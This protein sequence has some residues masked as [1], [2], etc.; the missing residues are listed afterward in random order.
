MWDVVNQ[1]K[2]DTFYTAGDVGSPKFQIE[3]VTKNE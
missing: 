2:I 3:E 1:I